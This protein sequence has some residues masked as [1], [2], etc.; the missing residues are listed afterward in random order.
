[1]KGKVWPSFDEAVADIPDGACVMIGGW[2]GPTS[3]PQNL[4]LALRDNGARDLTI[5]SA[6]MGLGGRNPLV[7]GATYI[8]PGI[9]IENKQVRKGITSW[10]R[11]ISPDVAAPVERAYLSGEIELELVPM[12]TLLER[13]RAGGAGI[14]GF[15]TRIGAGTQLAEGKE[16]RLLG[17]QRY[18]LEL[19]L[20][21][22][23]ALIRA[24]RADTMGNLVYRGTS[25]YNCPAMAIAARTTIVEVTEIVEPGEIDPNVIVTPG[26]YVDRIVQTAGV[27][28]A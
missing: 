27:A 8:D 4:I 24:H 7:P 22:D 26:V 25:R 23:Y 11:S 3:M 20:T 14:G 17:G 5:V 15:Y 2:T 9:L 18:V 6:I 16:E 12:G 28:G 10:A 19:P 21:A 1:M 13:I